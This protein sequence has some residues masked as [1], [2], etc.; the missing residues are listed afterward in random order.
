M[1]VHKQNLK[2][3]HTFSIGITIMEED[4]SYKFKIDFWS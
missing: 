4:T 3:F 1:F 2:C